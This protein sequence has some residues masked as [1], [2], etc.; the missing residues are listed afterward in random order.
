VA[1]APVDDDSDGLPGWAWALIG[2]ALGAGVVGLDFEI[3]RRR[4]QPS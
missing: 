3:R 2:D 1:A 4:R